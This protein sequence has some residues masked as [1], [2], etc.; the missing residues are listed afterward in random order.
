MRALQEAACLF[1]CSCWTRRI[2][3]DRKAVKNLSLFVSDDSSF[4][5]FYFLFLRISRHE[6]TC[7][8]LWSHY[9]Q[10]FHAHLCSAG[11]GG[12]GAWHILRGFFFCDYLTLQSRSTD[13]LIARTSQMFVWL[14]VLTSW[15]KANESCLPSVVL[16]FF[17]LLAAVPL[18]CWNGRMCRDVHS[19]FPLC[20]YV[21]ESQTRET[22]MKI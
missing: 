8:C 6:E 5:C 3:K 7:V 18:K 19:Y 20:K 4:V 21:W 22:C 14:C 16:A 17:S 11:A 15:K 12:E 13:L 10:Y 9:S 2:L 1:T